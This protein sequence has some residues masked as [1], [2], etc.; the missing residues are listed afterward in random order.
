MACSAPASSFANVIGREGSMK[1][2]LLVLVAAIACSLPASTMASAAQ[3]GPR[4]PTK[5]TF[6]TP[7]FQ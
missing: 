4:V 3:A 5:L 6:S 1:R 7:N 2:I